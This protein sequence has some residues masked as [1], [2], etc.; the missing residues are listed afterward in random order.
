M[1][2]VFFHTLGCRLNQ[3]EEES[4][5]R[6]FLAAGFV[7]T[8]AES[9]DLGII[10]TCSVTALADKKSRQ[11]IR[12]I[13]RKNKKMK[14]VVVGCGVEESRGLPEVDLFIPNEKKEKA[15]EITCGKKDVGA[16]WD[17]GGRTRALLKIQDGCGR[18]CAYCVVPRL[19]GKERSRPAAE[20]LREAGAL[21]GAGY[22]E[23]VL[24]GVNVGRYG[25]GLGVGLFKLLE[26]IL[27]E[28]GFFRIR[29]SSVNP[30][31]VTD[32]LIELWAAEPR[33]CRH[34]HLSLQS[35]SRAVLERMRRPYG[36]GEFLATVG[37]IRE[38][39]PEAAVTTD[40]IVGFPGETE[41]EF[42]ETCDFVRKVGFSKL[43]VFCYSK[44]KGT[45]AAGMSGQVPES[46]KKDRARV[47]SG[48]GEG[49]RQ[50]YA[51]RFLGQKLKVLFEEKKGSSWVG[52]SSNYLRIRKRSKKDLRNKMEL[53]EVSSENIVG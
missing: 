47:L 53:V 42:A 40:V 37:K 1:K 51:E 44:R 29:L 13:R 20:V 16:V 2:R 18:A 3:A 30:V 7:L 27:A 35:G 22:R 49:L 15:F 34:F 24:T 5:R 25:K 36:P 26:R 33:L 31:E 28:T 23:L 43:H 45:E 6:R 17:S 19:R 4:L 11:A 12:R 32:E 9:A 10:N 39:L 48:I 14:L 38:K 46:V 50:A 21:D 41:A 8:G 52:L